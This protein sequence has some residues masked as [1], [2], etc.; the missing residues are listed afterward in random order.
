[1]K[2]LVD[3]LPES[4]RDCLF[5]ETLGTGKYTGY[6]CILKMYIARADYLNRGYKPKCLCRNVTNCPHLKEV[7]Y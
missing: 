1:M 4:P 6:Y 7:G 5:S 2:I 3:K